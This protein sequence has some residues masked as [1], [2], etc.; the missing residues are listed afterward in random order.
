MFSSFHMNKCRLIPSHDSLR[1]PLVFSVKPQDDGDQSSL[2]PHLLPLHP[3]LTCLPPSMHQA[4]EEGPRSTDQITPALRPGCVAPAGGLCGPGGDERGSGR[5]RHHDAQARGRPWQHPR[6]KDETDRASGDGSGPVHLHLRRNA[7]VREPG[8]PAPQAGNGRRP[9]G[10][11]GRKQLGG[12]SGTA[13]LGGQ[14]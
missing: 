1:P 5:L 2:Q 10:P 3:L 7:A 13:Q 11:E 6:R 8:P 9:G 12:H 4:L 14:G